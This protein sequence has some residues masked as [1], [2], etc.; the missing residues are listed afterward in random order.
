[1]EHVKMGG[2]TLRLSMSVTGTASIRTN[3]SVHHLLAA[4]HFAR[5]SAQVEK[6]NTGPL[7]DEQSTEH[8][9]YV[10]AAIIAVVASMEATINELFL[11]AIEANPYTFKGLDPKLPKL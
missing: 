6:N 11:D 8:R 9:A 1:M 10:I 7:S 4:A 5:L 2:A 3:L